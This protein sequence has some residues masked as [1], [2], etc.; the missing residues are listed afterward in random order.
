MLH[1]CGDTSDRLGYIGET[2]FACFHFDS[3]V[4]AA[5]AMELA[6]GRIGLMGG[7]SNLDVIRTGDEAAIRSDVA[8]KVAVG[9]DII[10]PEC[11]VPLDAPYA[12]LKLHAEVAKDAGSP[13]DAS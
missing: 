1:I 11:A 2:G 7:T 3:R 4:P 12:N 5:T 9:I 8:E 6:D 13:S 10:G